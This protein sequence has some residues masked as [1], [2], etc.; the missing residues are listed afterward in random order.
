[1]TFEL[2]AVAFDPRATRISAADAG[3]HVVPNDV[4]EYAAAIVELMEDQPRRSRLGKL[5]RARVEVEPAWS[6]QERAYRG[7][8]AGSRTP[9]RTG[10]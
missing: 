8:I 4:N 1:M 3:V 6:H 2:P 5:G 7:V 9:A 10:G